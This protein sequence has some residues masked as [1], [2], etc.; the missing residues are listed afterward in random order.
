MFS[1]GSVSRVTLQ[2]KYNDDCCLQHLVVCQM[3]VRNAI[4]LQ[5]CAFGYYEGSAKTNLLLLLEM[6]KLI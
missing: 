4:S 6:V 2:V 1:I 3:L 5:P